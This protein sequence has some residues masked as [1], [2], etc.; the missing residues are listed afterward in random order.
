M[1]PR[2]IEWPFLMPN[3]RTRKELYRR[4]FTHA[5]LDCGVEYFGNKPEIKDYPRH[6][7]KDWPGIARIATKTWGDKL[8]V[9]IP[10]YPDDLNPGQFGD[11]VSKTLKNVEEFLSIDGVNW[12]VTIQG[13]YLNLLSIYESL[14]RTKELIGDYPHIAVGTVCKARKKKYIVSSLRAV[15][16]IFPKSQIHAFGVTLTCVK[17]LEPYIDSFDSMAW[18][19]PRKSFKQWSE[20][21]GFKPFPNTSPL[22]NNEANRFFWDSYIRRLKELEVL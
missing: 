18:C 4:K 16:A 11:N 10:D 7:L 3:P 1:P 5:I 20:E 9:T 19:F 21:T 13:R 8:L 22:T 15:R 6:F 2:G 14:Q 12:L 17:D